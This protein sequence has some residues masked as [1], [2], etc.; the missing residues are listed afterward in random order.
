SD[1]HEEGLPRHDH[2]L[3]QAWRARVV[4]AH[5]HTREGNVHLAAQEVLRDDATGGVDER[6][7]RASETELLELQHE[8]GEVARR[9]APHA[10]RTGL[11]RLTPRLADQG[12]ELLRELAGPVDD[13]LAERRR[14][15]TLT[16]PGEQAPPE[17]VLDPAELR[18][19]RGLGYAELR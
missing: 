14:S 10:Q 12:I 4:V 15:H 17:G 2:G 7:H 11:G 9:V 16:A 18:A 1:R 8:G 6:H 19:E 5:V 13:E 3:P